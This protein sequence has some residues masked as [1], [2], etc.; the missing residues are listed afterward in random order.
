MSG[1][2]AFAFEL[3]TFAFEPGTFAFEVGTVAFEVETFP[4]QPG[5]CGFRVG[6]F[7]ASSK[8]WAFAGGA[9]LD[10]TAARASCAAPLTSYGGSHFSSGARVRFNCVGFVA[11]C[12]DALDD[13]GPSVHC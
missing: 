11:G 1:V 12:G 5:T 13:G 7:A 10:V 6:A 4:F 8:G 9:E 2:G 3:G